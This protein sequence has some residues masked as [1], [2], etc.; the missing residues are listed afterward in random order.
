MHVLN[1]LASGADPQFVHATYLRPD[2]TDTQSQPQEVRQDLRCKQNGAQSFL[3]IFVFNRGRPRIQRAPSHFA[4][5]TARRF[6]DDD[7]DHSH[8]L[9]Q[10]GMNLLRDN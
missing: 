6:E 8:R 9:Q 4:A 1:F 2:P 7:T 10:P 5:A 3:G